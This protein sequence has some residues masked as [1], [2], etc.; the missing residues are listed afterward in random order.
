[1]TITSAPQQKRPAGRAAGA[2]LVWLLV[3]PGLLWAAV[4][5][6][7]WER[8]PLVQLFAFTPYVAAWSVPLALAA[9]LRRR[10][11]PGAF[12]VVAALALTAALLPRALADR[13]PAARGP[14]LRV[15]TAN[16]LAG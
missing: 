16:M 10:W 11:L 9:L 14:Q 12:A 2:A 8:G 13:Q 7:G 3:L 4:R 15:M 6:G 5:L 1:M